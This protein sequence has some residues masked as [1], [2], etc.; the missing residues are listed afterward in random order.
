VD[1]SVVVVLATDAPLDARQL[2]RL[3][4]RAQNGL[5][6]TGVSTAHGSGEF[7]LAFSTAPPRHRRDGRWL[8]PWFAAAAQVVEEAVLSSLRSAVT[9]TGRDGLTAHRCPVLDGDGR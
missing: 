3:A 8:D 2:G 4:R 1:G 6:R 5:A 9:T 7:V